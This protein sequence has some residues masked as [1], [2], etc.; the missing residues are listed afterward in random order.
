MDSRWLFSIRPV[1][2]I[3]CL[4]C[5]LPGA[6]AERPA[7]D[8][9]PVLQAPPSGS[10]RT[11]TPPAARRVLVRVRDGA[12]VTLDDALHQWVETRG[13]PVPDSITPAACRRFL[14]LLA[15]QVALTEAA[16]RAALPWTP[17]DSS[18][19][20]QL[21][22]RLV[23]RAALDSVLED[24]RR[25]AAA[26]AVD[27]E[28]LGVLARERVV[29]GLAVRFE[30][31]ALSRL[32]EEFRALPPPV[33]DSGLLG[34]IRAL[35]QAPRLGAG[36]SARVL[37]RSNEGD[38]L[39]SEVVHAWAQLPITYRP[40]VETAEQVRDL[41]ENLLFERV[42]RSTAARARL[43]ERPEI[44]RALA[45]HARS[46]ALS[47]YLDREVLSAIA[48]DSAAMRAYY[49]QHRDDWSVPLRVRGIR[50]FLSDHPTAARLAMRWQD[51]AAAET[52]AA[53]TLRSGVDYGF[54][55]SAASDS[56]LYRLAMAAGP[57]A[58][59]G[60]VS[61]GDS[62]WVARIREVVP[63]RIRRF[64]E[65]RGE[66][67]ERW[68]ADEAG[69]RTRALASWLRRSG[70]VALVPDAERVLRD[71]LRGMTRASGPDV[72]AR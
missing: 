41:A 29:A 14:D 55:V 65:V 17:E 11:T 66:V 42:L 35:E 21:R 64:D 26:P 30:D 16:R 58:V 72:N 61:Q 24:T 51:A 18:A 69:R 45:D 33:P 36:D 28:S 8:A 50:L 20:V 32:A 38:V 60:P 54:E 6:A 13:A 25:A 15:G 27:P 5:G 34:Q 46:S 53:L 57:G 9:A 1:W 49:A 48:P 4:A 40:R 62:W 37:A 71:A 19:H 10:A 31:D 68:F 12:G 59:V 63:G 39:A 67:A 7:H 43:A 2:V 3:A 22:D 23:M 52:L 47:R 44:R 56:S 70:H